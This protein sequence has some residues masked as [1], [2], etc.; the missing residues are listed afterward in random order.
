[1]AN[2]HCW[3]RRKGISDQF[4]EETHGDRLIVDAGQARGHGGGRHRP[5]DHGRDARGSARGRQPLRAGAHAD[6]GRDRAEGVARAGHDVAGKR[7]RGGA[8]GRRCHPRAGRSQRLPAGRERRHQSV[9]RFAQAPRPVRQHPP[10]EEPRRISAAL[11]RPRR[12]RHRAREHRRL[13]RR[14]QHVPGLGRIHADAGPCAIGT[15]DHTRR[16]DAH[17]RGGLSRWRCAGA[18]R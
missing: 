14:P 15:Q 2:C 1:M 10:G 17:R 11:R 18:R 5:R 9:G 13:L 8:G 16:L 7:G 12:S 4:A 3:L 6:A